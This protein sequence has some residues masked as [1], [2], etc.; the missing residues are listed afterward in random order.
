MIDASNAG[1]VISQD[2]CFE[3]E[4]DG[5][6]VKLPSGRLAWKRR[7]QNKREFVRV[8]YTSRLMEAV[9]LRHLVLEGLKQVA[10][11]RSECWLDDVVIGWRYDEPL[12]AR[13]C[14]PGKVFR[15]FK[16]E[17]WEMGFDPQYC[18][19]GAGRHVDFLSPAAL[20]LIPAEGKMHVITT[21]TGITNNGQLQLMMNSGLNHIPMRALDEDVA[22]TEVEE[23]LGCILTT[24]ICDEELSMEQEKLVKDFVMTRAKASIREYHA[25]HRHIK[26][27]PINNVPVRSE[28][29]W[30]TQRYLVCPTDKAPHTP[31]FVCINFIRRLAL[32]RLSG[33][34]FIPLQPSPAAIGS[35][36]AEE[37]NALAPVGCSG[38]KALLPHLMVVYKAHKD[39]FRWIT[40]TSRSV[41]SPVAEVCTCLLKFLAIDVQ[42]LCAG[43][44]EAS[45]EKR[46]VRP[47]Y[48]WPIASIGEFVANL[49]RHVY[50]VFT[51]DI[52][53]CF[54][55]IPI[56]NSDDGLITAI[57][58]FVVCA[59]EWRRVRTAR[60]VVAIRVAANG[61]LHPS[62]VDGQ[63]ERQLDM[64][65]FSEAEIISTCD[66]LISNVVVQMGD[67]ELRHSGP[68]ET[69]TMDYEVDPTMVD[70]LIG[71]PE[72]AV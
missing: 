30:L 41:L 38:D 5:C 20:R 11:A 70:Q 64:L 72:D 31:T 18:R 19:C 42:M 57:R 69:T 22:V 45:F 7:K 6:F 17:E 3:Q 52:I 12:G 10:G 28:I 46:G 13:I 37:A 26:E 27:E 39:T 60:D 4:E 32:E 71:N 66:C 63:Q 29:E 55:K 56:D 2:E 24:K 25:Q 51:A 54:E 23:A 43:K 50:S 14:K 59:M 34:D 16:L 48:W 33:P 44:S 35:K 62:W 49:P 36:I 65:Y 15:K 53:R 8:R 61:T 68:E 47:N 1:V 67:R 58:F 9:S 21:D 40:N